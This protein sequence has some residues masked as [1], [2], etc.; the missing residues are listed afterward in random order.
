MQI[1]V[2]LQWRE[3]DIIA[4]LF[5]Q[6]SVSATMLSHKRAFLLTLLLL[7]WREAECLALRPHSFS[8]L[9]QLPE[10]RQIISHA[11]VPAIASCAGQLQQLAAAAQTQHEAE[12]EA[13]LLESERR[14]PQGACDEESLKIRAQAATVRAKRA[15][16]KEAAA[17]LAPQSPEATLKAAAE[18]EQDGSG[19]F[20]D[21][22]DLFNAET[23][24]KARQRWQKDTD[25]SLLQ[26]L[27]PGL[28]LCLAAEVAVG[29]LC[30][31]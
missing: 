3:A 28:R 23:M 14:I 8:H 30:D 27:A 5:L 1:F 20:T 17:A 2:L 12:E 21:D 29:M 6:P 11:A 16:V 22:A 9:K 13:A 4:M 31:G 26:Q 7:Q 19:D 18:A 25:A 24:A 15:A 10:L